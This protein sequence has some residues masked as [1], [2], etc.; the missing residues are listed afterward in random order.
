MSR[1]KPAPCIAHAVFI[2]THTIIHFM[3]GFMMNYDSFHAQVQAQEDESS[4]HWLDSPLFS[5]G[6]SES[7]NLCPG[8]SIEERS[9]EA[10]ILDIL[11]QP[12]VGVRQSP[13]L[14]ALER[15]VM[16]ALLHHVGALATVLTS[17][18]GPPSSM[19]ALCHSVSTAARDMRRFV[20]DKRD[21]DNMSL[22]ENEEPGEWST[23]TEPLTVRCHF[24]L[25]INPMCEV[26]EGDAN[27]SFLTKVKEVVTLVGI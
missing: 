4:K 11:K 1:N 19:A 26:T 24:I 9:P 20:M 10:R 22:K 14:D 27:E 6:M 8:L 3:H 5:K 13:Y 25:R 21:L 7:E 17:A 2:L 23:Y 16:A 15:T 12:L 18:A